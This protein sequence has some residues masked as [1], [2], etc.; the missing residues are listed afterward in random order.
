MEMELAEVRERW[1]PMNLTYIGQ[2][3]D[4]IQGGG[5]KLSLITGDP[6]EPFRCPPG[7]CA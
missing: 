4:V 7:Q 3:E 5:G 6:G 1:E 2:V